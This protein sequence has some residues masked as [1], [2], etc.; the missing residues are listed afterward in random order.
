MTRIELE[1]HK[2]E[3]LKMSHL[4]MAKFYRF[5]PAGHIYFGFELWRTFETRFKKLG[6]MTTE[7]SK[8]I[9]W[10]E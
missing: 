8:Q 10:N 4:E 2:A 5:A 9:G 3:I 7:I 6:G 1:K